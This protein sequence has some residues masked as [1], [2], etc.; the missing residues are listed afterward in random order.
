M[1]THIPYLDGWR[2]LAIV[3][4]LI[5]HFLPVPGLNFGAIGVS[6]FFVE[7]PA[8]IW[9]NRVLPQ[10]IEIPPDEDDVPMLQP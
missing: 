9:L 4:L 1:K 3:F 6:L 2:G 7:N 5:G 8:R 10:K